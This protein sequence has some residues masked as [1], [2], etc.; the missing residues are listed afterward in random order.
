MAD[1]N[2]DV[3]L[4]LYPG[5]LSPTKEW[6]T[7]GSNYKQVFIFDFFERDDVAARLQ[8]GSAVAADYCW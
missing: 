8:E 2:P 5:A 3:P 6:I 1:L 4:I 7:G